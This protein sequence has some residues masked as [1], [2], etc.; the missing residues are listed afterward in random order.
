MKILVVMCELNSLALELRIL[1]EQRQAVLCIDVAM[2]DADAQEYY[3]ARVCV[4]DATHNYLQKIP[5]SMQ[6]IAA[7]TEGRHALEQK[8]NPSHY[9][10][11]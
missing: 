7:R 2:H 1:Q 5:N 3:V 6:V 11:L 8:Q 9:L 10:D 4:N